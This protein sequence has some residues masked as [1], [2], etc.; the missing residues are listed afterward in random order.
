MHTGLC[1]HSPLR[2]VNS[3]LA[4]GTHG[5]KEL[6]TGTQDDRH[7]GAGQPGGRCARS[8]RGIVGAVWVD[9]SRHGAQRQEEVVC[10]M[11]AVNAGAAVLAWRGLG[12]QTCSDWPITSAR[13][14]LSWEFDVGPMVA[15]SQS[16]CATKTDCDPLAMC[17]PCGVAGSQATAAGQ[18][19]WPAQHIV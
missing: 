17:K 16:C 18:H 13:G 5:W 19:S 15:A 3:T 6:L 2:T 11:D 1:G 12:A 10:L 14:Q 8:G 9:L 4:R 7:A